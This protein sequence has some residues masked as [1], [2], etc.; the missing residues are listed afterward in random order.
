[1]S[2]R[3]GLKDSGERQQF[4]TGS[5][6]DTQAGKG[7]PDLIPTLWIRRLAA[8]LEK[9]AAKYGENN[10][11]KGQPLSQFYA[12]G[13]RH[14]LAAKD[15]MEDEDHLFQAAWNFMSLAWTLEEIRAGR[16]PAELN[17]LPYKDPSEGIAHLDHPE[18]FDGFE[19]EYGP[20]QEAAMDPE[21]DTEAE[22][23]LARLVGQTTIDVVFRHTKDCNCD[24]CRSN[25][26]RISNR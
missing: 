10:W 13:L 22:A 20:D 14:M 12:S 26:T 23:M 4:T 25:R 8:V 9:G 19:E 2:D 7:R 16:L 1:M 11:Q 6:R 15:G 21:R 3:F 24:L 17:D 18:K 5:Q